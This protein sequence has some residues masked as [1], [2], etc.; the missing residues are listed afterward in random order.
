MIK[1]S[2]GI[3]LLLA[4]LSVKYTVIFSQ[5]KGVVKAHWTGST[6]DP[7]NESKEKEDER[8]EAK[9][10]F[11]E[12]YQESLL[13]ALEMPSQRLNTNYLLSSTTAYLPSLYLPPEV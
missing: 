4:F 2:I 10:L 6:E 1:R 9:S 7:A 3:L 5:S 11:D 13:I 12:F 8:K